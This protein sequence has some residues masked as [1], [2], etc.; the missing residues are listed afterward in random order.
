MIMRNKPTIGEPKPMLTK[1]L[2]SLLMGAAFL[3][4]ASAL[5]AAGPA[6]VNLRS[7]AHF[8]VLAGAAVT[9]TGGGEVNGDVGASP[10]S[11][12][13]IHVTQAQVNGTIYAVDAAGPHGSVIAPSLL[14]TAMGDLTAAINDAAGRP[15]ATAPPF[16]NP[17]NGNIGGLTLYPGL[18]TFAGTA[19]ITGSDVTLMGG[20]DDVWIFQ[21]A[22]D[23]EEGGSIQVILA[24]GAQ[25]RNIF[26]Q[27]GT[28]ATIG[29]YAVFK[30]TILA[31]QAVSMETG[32][33]VD[34]RALAFNAGVTFDGIVGTLPT[35]K[36][37]EFDRISLTNTNS[38]TLA[39][40]TTP[41]FPATIQSCTNLAL[42]VWTTIATTN[43][44]T[45]L[46]TITITNAV[47][48]AAQTYYRAFIT[49]PN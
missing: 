31:Y 49:T 7:T 44:T 9:T 42:P 40:T 2:A 26:W 28:S 12:S 30:G 19:S 37:P 20:P 16:L 34:G 3:G 23:L 43:P 35:P 22:D 6:P 21:V 29:T 10:I 13:A 32:S 18:Y 46:W 36:A 25:A 41:F 38:I 17:G 5:M 11:G 48:A 47:A 27:V 24:G 33:A 8:T 14:S 4:P 15:A 1:K 39:L 45:N